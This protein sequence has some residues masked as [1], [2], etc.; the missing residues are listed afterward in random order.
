MEA[1]TMVLGNSL[2]FFLYKLGWMGF[3]LCRDGMYFQACTRAEL[4]LSTIQI[5]SHVLFL[6]D[7]VC[8]RTAGLL[9]DKVLDGIK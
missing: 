1:E 6:W 9:N 3:Q 5:Q 2:I 4:S 8:A 7:E